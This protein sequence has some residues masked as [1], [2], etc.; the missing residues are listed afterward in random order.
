MTHTIGLTA[1]HSHLM[2]DK[3]ISLRLSNHQGKQL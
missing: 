2:S 3:D 1:I